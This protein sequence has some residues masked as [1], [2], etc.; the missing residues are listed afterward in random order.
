MLAL[1]ALGATL[2][3]AI[4]YSVR[5]PGGV[6]AADAAGNVYTTGSVPQGNGPLPTTPGAP[7]TAL[8][9]EPD[10]S[11]YLA[12]LDPNGQVVFLTY[13]VGSTRLIAV[14]ASGDVF[15]SG[16]TADAPGTFFV[17]EVNAA[18][19]KLLYY[20]VFGGNGSINQAVGI[21]VDGQSNVYVAGNTNS[22]N[23]PVTPGSY[24][25][26]SSGAFVMKLNPNT[27]QIVYSSCCLG[28]PGGAS[29]TGVGI[30]GSGNAYV[31]GNGA[32]D[33]PVTAR[34]FQPAGLTGNYIAELNA[35]GSGLTYSIFF[36][37]RVAALAVDT[38]GA[39]YLTGQNLDPN[40]YGVGYA[41]PVTPG[42]YETTPASGGRNVYVGYGATFI[43]KLNPG[44]GSLAFCTYSDGAEAFAIAVDS[45]GSPVVGGWTDSPSFPTVNPLQAS[46]DPDLGF[47]QCLYEPGNTRSSASCASQFLTR[48]DSQGKQLVW[49]TYL[50]S[51][52]TSA[53]R[54]VA[55]DASD[56]VY[57]AASFPGL[58][59]PG[60]TVPSAT[61]VRIAP[62]GPPPLAV[63]AGVVSSA[64]FTSSINSGGLATIFGTGLTTVDGVVF[65]TSFPLPTELAGTSVWLDGYPAPLLAVAN[66]NGQQQ[67]NFQVPSDPGFVAPWICPC[68]PIMVRSPK[69]LGFV[70]DWGAPPYVAQY[71]VA[72]I[73]GSGPGGTPAIVHGADYSLVTASNPAHPGETIV[74]YATGLGA[75]SPQVAVGAAAPLTPLS[76][77]T[78]TPKVL[79][80]GV[81]G[82][83][84][85]SGLAPGYAGL[86]QLNVVVPQVAAGLQ[87]VTIENP[88]TGLYGLPATITVQ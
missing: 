68:P 55:T 9:A 26:G 43:A 85:F 45:S 57:A 80:G 28:G 50:G 66:V 25:V 2:P 1:P 76:Q 44:G 4:A 17:A 62:I 31:I 81:G 39:V 82:V 64:D 41:L 74:I 24:H 37:A 12:K 61:I 18:G 51:V 63:P 78:Y 77:T 73:F 53:V 54:Q 33:F 13:M 58:S 86:Y 84:Q 47:G 35:T 46:P 59:M 56:N 48:L 52:G 40:E 29:A 70:F 11:S 65:A 60:V 88:A 67:I 23:F 36:P 79:I 42:A 16:S 71:P 75:V 19:T 34:P 15:L 38:G 32:A 21:A 83:V 5:T 49:S 3:P 10:V 8:S 20:Q 72:A 6:F 22:T 14:N 87:T 69:G 30:D 7:Y 27:S